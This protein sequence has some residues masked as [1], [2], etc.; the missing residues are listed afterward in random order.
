MHRL[1]LGLLFWVAILTPAL[2]NWEFAK[3]GM[4]LDELIAASGGKAIRYSEKEIK[5]KSTFI[6]YKCQAYMP[7]YATGKF[8]FEVRFCFDARENLFSV[9]L[10][11]DGQDFYELDR[12]LR[13]VFGRPAEEKDGLVPSRIWTDRTK[14]NVVRLVRVSST[15]LQYQ[16][17]AKG[18]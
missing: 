17:I 8:K 15:I 3:W 4:T 11:T 14:G 18:F 9:D 16:P 12:T 1:L 13:G 5:E 2:A 6:G 7:N 10:Y